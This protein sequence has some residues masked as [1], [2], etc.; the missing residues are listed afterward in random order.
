MT[1]RL[2]NQMGHPPG[3]VAHPADPAQLRRDGI[4]VK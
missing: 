4:V 3:T 2:M 1:H